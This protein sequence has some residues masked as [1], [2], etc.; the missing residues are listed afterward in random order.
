MKAAELQCAWV[1]QAHLDAERGVIACRMCRKR[2]G[3][4]EAVTLWRNGGLVFAL[5]DRC[6]A[7]HDLLMRATEVGIEVRA[8]PRGPLV[9]G[10]TEP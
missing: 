9:V 1:K 8:R 2:A 3:L 10:G 6:A 5:C 4:D 7:S